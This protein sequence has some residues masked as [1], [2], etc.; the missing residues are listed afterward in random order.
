M[1]LQ[2][3]EDKINELLKRQDKVKSEIGD[4]IDELEENRK[5]LN[6][7]NVFEKDFLG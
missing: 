7:K 3:K 2:S 6:E 1:L 4:K 5:L